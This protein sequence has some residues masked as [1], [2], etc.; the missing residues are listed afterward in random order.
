MTSI[1]ARLTGSLADRY[2]LV[3]ELGQGGMA[4]V[5]LA[6]DIRHRRNVAIK[7]LHPELSAVLG[8]ER[9]LKEIELTANL[10]HPHI[11]PLFDSGA[12][13]GLL[14]YV[15]PYVEGESLRSRLTREKQLSIPD[16]VRIAGEVAGALDYAHRRGVVH[17]D[18]KPENILL[19]DGRPMVAD[20]GIALAVVQAGGSRMT[21][22]G[23]SLGTPQ[24]MSPEQA[25]GEREITPRSDLYALGC[26]TYEM[27]TG[28]PP[29]S[30]ATAQAI[31]A[32]V[33]T[34]APRPILPQRHTVPEHVEAAVLTALE[35]LPA[36]RWGSAK[37]FAD[38]LTGSVAV[39]LSGRTTAA[40]PAAAPPRRRAALLPWILVV[41]FAALTAW[42]L[43]KHPAITSRP[44]IRYSLTPPGEIRVLD[45]G[46]PPAVVTPDGSKMVF[47]GR[48]ALGQPP[49]LFVW[50]LGGAAPV[51]LTGTENG[52]WPFLSPDGSWVGF[53]ASGQLRRVPIGGGSVMTMGDAGSDRTI[54][55][56]GSFRGATWTDRNEIVYATSTGMRRMSVEGGRPQPLRIGGD[57]L[58]PRTSG[59]FPNALP[60][61][62]AILV[63]L[64]SPASPRAPELAVISL[65]DGKARMLGQQ[66]SNPHYVEPGFLAFTAADGTLLG[67]PFDRRRGK[68][69]G[70]PRPVAEGIPL[71][72]FGVGKLDVAR[73][74]SVVYFEGLVQEQRQLLRVDRHGIVKPLD[75]PLRNYNGP[76][77]SPDGR[78]IAVTIGPVP[79]P[80]MDIWLY[81]LGVGTLTRVTFDSTS[82][83]PEW[84]ADGKRLIHRRA[85]GNF[86]VMATTPDG[87]RAPDSLYGTVGD[88]W[89]TLPSRSGDTLITR[90][91]TSPENDRDLML[92]PLKPR[93]PAVPFAGGPRIQAQP[94]LSPDGKWLAYASD[95]SGSFEVY[96]KAF[97]GPGPRYQASAGGGMAPRWNPRGGELFLNSRDSLI[98]V[99]VRETG[100][101][102]ELGRGRA[103]FADRFAPL[104][105]HAHYDVSP[106]GTWFVFVGSTDASLS[107]QDFGAG[108]RGSFRVVLNW[109]EQQQK[110]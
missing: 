16:A 99:P 54:Q 88:L 68:L 70:Q 76:R 17:R 8:T 86:K 104:N 103:L 40:T 23:L 94:A 64:A 41:A 61:G 26:I 10:Q 49:Q 21:Q 80:P 4:T 7:V 45:I 36:D 14:Y 110:P 59:F 85:T 34:E 20:F 51:V 79:N 87:S 60:G 101:T 77:I 48:H 44:V 63:S 42:A 75:A 96:V 12:A 72:T 46:G 47:V 95:E 83:H 73:G 2:R 43:L 106:D 58:G 1:D 3:R 81:D 102:L 93:G 105:Y 69:T 19:H 5:Y 32:R 65:A 56:V 15:M 57:S 25:M 50:D 35:K 89:E 92:V 100:G 38:A 84:T 82:L 55:A 97:P 33:L 31:V 66:G 9:F 28:E 109:F 37:E 11:L 29:F 78:R 90:E 98:A 24:Y 39:R 91:I 62:D 67:A 52:N 6:E 53:L 13:D 108:T 18:I 30:G 22:T 71:G 74:G 107:R 27:L